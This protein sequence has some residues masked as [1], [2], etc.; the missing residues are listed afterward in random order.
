VAVSA[1]ESLE[2]ELHL[3]RAVV[4]MVPA[5]LAYWDASQRCVFAN[6]AYEKRF[7]ISPDDLIGCTMEELLGPIYPLNLPYIESR[8]CQYASRLIRSTAWC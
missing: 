8:S 6:R 2:R 3:T 5:M 4:N 7:N 1:T